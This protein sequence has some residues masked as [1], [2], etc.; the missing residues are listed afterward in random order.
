MLLRK[1]SSNR[2]PAQKGSRES[3]AISLSK[4]TV[5]CSSGKKRYISNTENLAIS[6]T[7]RS[8]GVWLFIGQ[9]RGHR[10]LGQA[11]SSSPSALVSSFFRCCTAREASRWG[12]LRFTSALTHPSRYT[13]LRELIKEAV[14]R[15]FL[16]Y[17][18]YFT[19]IRGVSV[20]SF[21]FSR[22]S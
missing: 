8:D 13:P 16:G 5:A 4:T 1:N 21:F 19:I 10:N 20:A 9:F 17:L 2:I 3:F 12:E 22:V 6:F 11:T 15:R 14:I 7:Q 18:H